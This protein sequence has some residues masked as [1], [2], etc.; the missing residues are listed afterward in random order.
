MNTSQYF[1]LIVTLTNLTGLYTVRFSYRN[2]LYF[3]MILIFF[4]MCASI[5]HHISAINRG[6]DAIYLV[7]YSY[8]LLWFDRIMAFSSIIRM[9]YLV[10]EYNIH[11]RA[12]SI[13]YMLVILALF[14]L[15][16]SDVIMYH[17]NT[18]DKQ[19]RYCFTHSIWHIL[20]FYTAKI[21]LAYSL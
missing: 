14:C 19:F 13:D 1:N 7:S 11:I 4:T 5:L 18:F 17:N 6:L 12:N 3:D 15:F 20:A 21:V 9:L 2:G 10:Y 8:Q 16:Y